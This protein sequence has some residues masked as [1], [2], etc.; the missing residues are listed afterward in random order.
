MMKVFII[1]FGTNPH[2]VTKFQTYR[3][4]NGDENRAEKKI[5]KSRRVNR[6]L[7]TATYATQTR[8]R[9]LLGKLQTIEANCARENGE[10]LHVGRVY[11]DV[12]LYWSNYFNLSFSSELHDVFPEETQQFVCGLQAALGGLR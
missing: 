2:I 5:M 10:I 4:R 1:S 9:R 7:A 11:S 6:T 3:F 12:G 8:P